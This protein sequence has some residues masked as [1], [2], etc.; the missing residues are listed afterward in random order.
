MLW[1]SELL[2]RDG[3]AAGQVVS[4]AWGESCGDEW[5]SRTSGATTVSPSP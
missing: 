4:A 3:Q 5:G 1:G 2:L